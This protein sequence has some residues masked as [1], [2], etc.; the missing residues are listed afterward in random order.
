MASLLSTGSVGAG[1][2]YSM[3][4]VSSKY[5]IRSNT[6]YFLV[7]TMTLYTYVSLVSWYFAENFFAYKLALGMPGFLP[8]FMYALFGESPKWLFAQNKHEQAIDSIAKACRINGN[9]LP[10]QTVEELRAVSAYNRGKPSNTMQ[11]TQMSLIDLFREKILTLRLII[12][13]LVWFYGFFALSGT[14]FGSA[15]VHSNK[16]LSFLII[17]LADVPGNIMGTYLMNRIGRKMSIGS[18]FLIYGILVIVS[19]QLPIDGHSRLTVYFISKISI[20][21]AVTGLNTYSSE[22]WPTAIRNTAFSIALTAGRFGS[23]VASISLTLNKYDE[24]IPP[25]LYAISAIISSILLFVFLPETMHCDKLP[26]TI[27]E[28]LDIGQNGV[29]IEEQEDDQ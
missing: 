19:T 3:E 7:Q 6:I 13:S 29:E 8:I 26:D 9:P 25:I 23:V 20:A 24:H 27:E 4:W 10:L 15:S 11:S 14:I 28:A 1:F 17:G 5:R 21:C 22:F 18:T 16:Y 12:L 2:V